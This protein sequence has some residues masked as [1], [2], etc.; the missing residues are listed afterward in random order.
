MIQTFSQF[1]SCGVLNGDWKIDFYGLIL[2]N[3]IGKK[4]NPITIM[5]KTI[6]TLGYSLSLFLFSTTAFAEGLP[7][8]N[9]A[10]NAALKYEEKARL[11]KKAG[12]SEKARIYLRMA[13]IKRE[14]KEFSDRGETYDWT[15]YHELEGQLNRIGSEKKVKQN[16]PATQENG[17][18][19]TAEKYE[20][21]AKQALENGD[22]ERANILQQM[23]EIKRQAGNGHKVDWDHYH[24]LAAKL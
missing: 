17:F 24:A 11:A 1:R 23:A 8:G 4:L 9:W 2:S 20:K 19:K 14:S 3:Q 6:K 21:Q 18:L 15:E 16:K 22:K 10:E 12:E 13:A 7:K 5:L